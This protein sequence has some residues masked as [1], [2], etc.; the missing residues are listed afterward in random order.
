MERALIITGGEAPASIPTNDYSRIIAADSGYELALALSL[1]PD[2]VVGDFDSTARK[3][4]LLDM[5]Y[6]MAPV[7]KDYTD[8]ELALVSLGGE[9]YDL[10]G[11]GGGRIEHILSLFAAFQK[12]SPPL[13]WFT[14]SNLIITA[15]GK[16]TLN[17]EKGTRISFFSMPSEAVRV[18]SKGLYWPLD[19]LVLSSA[20]VSLSN[21]TSKEV[22]TLESARRFFISLPSSYASKEKFAKLISTS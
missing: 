15:K 18:R 21:K 1:K 12:F 22:V 4:E 16:I 17:L 2:L 8:T 7:D 13:Y 3:K 5:G 9:S 20:F 14:K 19:D 11:G 6:K 10:A